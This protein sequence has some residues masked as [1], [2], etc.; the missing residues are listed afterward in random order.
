MST[1]VGGVPEVLPDDMIFMAK[2]S[3]S[4]LTKNLSKAIQ[5]KLDTKIEHQRLESI[6]FHERIKNMYSWTNVTKRTISVYEQVL[7]QPKKTFLERL[8]RY[9]SVGPFAGY[10]ASI[11]AI[12]LHLYVSLCQWWQS[13]EFIDRITTTTID[14]PYHQ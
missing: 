1:N 4:D 13:E 7:Q 11:L 5:A 2:P 9:R 3:V 8:G 6:D 10:V 14:Q 12:T